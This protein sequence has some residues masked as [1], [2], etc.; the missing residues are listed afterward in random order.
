[1]NLPAAGVGTRAATVS[2]SVLSTGGDAPEIVVYYGPTN[3]GTNAAGWAQWVWLGSQSGNFA[4]TLTGLTPN[5]AYYFACAAVNAAGTSWGAPSQNFTTA[6]VSLAS[7]TNLPASNLT[8]NSALLSGQVLSTGNDA[9][10]LTLY[11][12]PSNGGNNPGAWAHSASLGL[13]VGRF[14]QTVT[15]L[16]PSTTFYFTAAATNGAGTSWATPVASFTTPATNPVPS[17]LVSVVTYRNAKDRTGQNTNE[18]SLTP[19]NV[20]SNMFGKL[21]SYAIDGYMTAQPLVL[22]NVNIPGKGVHNVVFAFTEHDSVY[23]FDADSNSGANANPLWKVSFINPAAGITTVSATGDLAG[24][25]GGFVGPELG[26]SGTPVIDTASGTL[27]VVAITKEVVGGMTNFYNRLHALDVT[28]GSEKFGGPVVIQGSVPGVGDGNDG[29]GNV[30]F[31]QLKH[32]QR[33]S[34]LFQNGTVY[35]PFT[36]HFDYPPYHGWVFAYNAYS[37]AQ[38]A[39][40]NANPNGSGGGFW[41]SG[42]GPAADPAGNLYLESGNGN[43]DA[44]HANYGDSVVKLSTADGGLALIDYFTPYNQLSLN[45]QD[46]DLGSAGQILLPDSAGSVAHP[47]LMIAT[48]K[49][50]TQYLL[51]RDNLGQ[52]NAGADGQIVQ[53]VSGVVGGMWCTPGWFNGIAYFIASGQQLKALAVSN[54]L[55]NSTPLGVGPTSIGSA[56]PSISA[57]GTNNGIVWALQTSS[58]AVL[59]AYNATNVALELYNSSQNSTRDNPGSPVKFTCPTV[60]NGKV[61]ISTVN[62]LTVYGNGAF[63]AIPIISPNG[64]TFTNS[65]SVTI[66]DAVP[67]TTIYYTLDGSTPTTNSILYTGPFMLTTSAGVQAVGTMLGSPNSLVTVATFYEVSSLGRGTGLL[68]QYYSNSFP[69]NPFVG[70]PLVRTDSVVNFNWNSIG[71]DPTIGTVNYT[72]RW[73]GMVQPAFNETYTFWTTTDDGVRLWVNGQLLVDHWSPQSPTAWSGSFALQ[74]GH[75]YPIEMDYFQAGGGAVAQLAWSSP[76][77]TQSLIPRTQLYPITTL[78]PLFFSGD[79]SFT[80]GSFLVQASGF[81]GGS[82]IFQGSTDLVH[83]VSLSTNT[84][85]ANL[86][87]LID[88]SAT[89]YPWRFYRAIQ[90]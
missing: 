9:P 55:I 32:H 29:H 16:S 42:C 80:N 4:L 53:S 36:G 12:G 49:T 51:D 70:S 54:G 22:A 7:A 86:F 74:A 28:T 21:F 6:N 1:M 78:P 33:S 20:N 10:T 71:P 66:S 45:L 41:Q 52:F 37:L 30:P 88:S 14:A 79:G 5:T 84:A 15:G 40:W 76:S 69:A 77:T 90:R 46:L 8:T 60:A 68:G 61:Y 23:A 75:L 38:T 67:G 19:A 83:W 56:S 18:T 39:I 2:G 35:I 62:T 27:Y 50:G 65:I 26:I 43:W 17:P 72:V 47:H 64:G 3:G 89:K 73:T 82:Y 11:Y 85:S 59:H 44:V 25:A 58:P 57:N 31:V 48:G 63:L 24:I 34:L 87:D 81:A 13:Q